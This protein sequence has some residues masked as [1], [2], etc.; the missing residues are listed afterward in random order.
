MHSHTRRRRIEGHS[1]IHR[2]GPGNKKFG[3]VPRPPSRAWLPRRSALPLPNRPGIST[4]AP[5]LVGVFDPSA[6]TPGVERLLL[7]L[8][9]PTGAGETGP[10]HPGMHN[11]VSR[12]RALGFCTLRSGRFALGR[13]LE[14]VD[15]APGPLAWMQRGPCGLGP[16]RWAVLLASG[17]EADAFSWPS[18]I[19][20]PPL[21]ESADFPNSSSREAKRR[22]PQAGSSWQAATIRRRPSPD[23]L[24][25]PSRR[26]RLLP[27]IGVSSSPPDDPSRPCRT[28]LAGQGLLRHR[29]RPLEPR[30]EGA[31]RKFDIRPQARAILTRSTETLSAQ[32]RPSAGSPSSFSSIRGGQADLQSR[33]Q[34]VPRKPQ[35]ICR[36]AVS[37]GGRAR[38]PV[39]R[40]GC[41]SAANRL[42]HQGATNCNR[43]GQLFTFTR[44]PGRRSSIKGPWRSQGPKHIRDRPHHP[45]PTS[46]PRTSRMP[47]KRRSEV[48]DAVKQENESLIQ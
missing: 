41:G 33:S 47:C 2:A 13:P 5:Y 23:D 8:L 29:F 16:V 17:P 40:A 3:W 45:Q 19:T 12:W 30:P 1:L 38:P 39:A 21:T 31:C 37:G 27:H 28:P 14:P 9:S 34:P 10:I 11:F 36:S 4:P 22:S 48:R 20:P 18:T 6:T 7:Y 25:R 24:V 43:T 35:P 44:P 15:A 46:W 26:G 42:E 32:V